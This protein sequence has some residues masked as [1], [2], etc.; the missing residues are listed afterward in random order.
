MIRY[1]FVYQVVIMDK[2]KKERRYSRIY[3]QI[4]GL[5][6]KTEDRMARMATITAVLHQKMEYFF[7]TGFYTI[8]NNEMTVMSY[9]GPVAC[10]ILARDS[11]VC[12][13]A[14][15]RKETVVVEDV[16]QFPGHI[17]C[18]SRSKSEI[19]IPL[20]DNTGAIYGVFDID[21]TELSSF[22][23]VDKHWLEKIAFL[24]DHPEETGL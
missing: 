2:K 7:W 20:F 22:D 10:Q 24:I 14:Y 19:V 6:N 16:E 3:D 1:C 4:A 9:Q 21:S 11:G 15:N 5:L 18:D 8:R 13:A 12:W 17:A 23:E